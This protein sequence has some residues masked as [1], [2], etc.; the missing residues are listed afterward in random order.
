MEKFYRE[1]FNE[2]MIKDDGIKVKRLLELIDGHKYCDELVKLFD[3]KSQVNE[4]I[5]IPGAKRLV[6]TI[7]EKDEE[8]KKFDIESKLCDV[9]FEDIYDSNTIKLTFNNI[10]KPEVLEITNSSTIEAETIYSSKSDFFGKFA[11]NRFVDFCFNQGNK[12]QVGKTLDDLKDYYTG[13][14]DKLR[15]YRIVKDKEDKYFVRAITSIKHYRDYNIRIAV[16]IALMSLHK[17]MRTQNEKYK[18]S[19]CEYNESNLRMYFEQDGYKIIEG[20]GKARFVLE[21]VNGEIK[22]DSL[23]FSG[24]YAIE[25]DKADEEEQSRIYIKPRNYKSRILTISHLFTLP[26]A[27]EEMKNL[28]NMLLIET[29]L[30]DDIKSIAKIKKP[31]EIRHLLFKKLKH[32]RNAKLSSY[33][34]KLGELNL[35]IDSIH[36]LLKLLQ[37]AD[38][39][40]SDL[41][42]KEYL[43]Y[44]VYDILVQRK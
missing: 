3:F 18:V 11:L 44:I 15:R 26:T 2:S 34:E 39:I 5:A 30:F 27:L 23:R 41:E 24:V 9:E 8:F 28:D 36:D 1:Y 13:E 38:L 25:F 7:I 19:F 42:A 40:V 14:K 37:K 35:K 21:V 32:S 16:F 22:K 29:E 20:V 10:E 4:Y 17:R 6:K 43:K 33:K 12:P 31:D